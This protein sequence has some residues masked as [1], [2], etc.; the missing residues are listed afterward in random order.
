[1][2]PLKKYVFS[3]LFC[4]NKCHSFQGLVSSGLNHQLDV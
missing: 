2:L 1:M 3:I 4:L